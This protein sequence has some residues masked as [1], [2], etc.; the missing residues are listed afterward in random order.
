MLCIESCKNREVTPEDLEI[1]DIH[2]NFPDKFDTIQVFG[3]DYIILERDRNNPHEGFG[4]M[5][6]RGD[7]LFANQDSAKAYQRLILENQIRIIARL[8][9]RTIED[10]RFE[11]EAKLLEELS[12]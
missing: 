10:V 1:R 12:K 9:G 8:E 11:M 5:A 4:F 6:L 7:K 2:T 3:Q